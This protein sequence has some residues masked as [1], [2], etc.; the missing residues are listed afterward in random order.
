MPE[1][2]DTYTS[3]FTG[4]RL[5]CAG[6]VGESLLHL[7]MLNG[8]DIHIKVAKRL[9]KFY[10]CQINDI[11]MG[12]DY[13]GENALHMAIVAENPSLVKYLLMQGADY[14]Q[15]CT[16]KFFTAADQKQFRVDHLENEHPSLPV[17]SNYE[18]VSYFGEYPLS[19]AAIMNQEECIRLLMAKGADPN[20]QDS[21][22]NTVLHMLVINDMLD[23]FKIMLT[24]KAR[25]DIKNRQGL[26][27][28]TLAAKLARYNMF[29]FILIQQRKLLWKY[30][31]IT[32][33]A[34][35]IDTV[36]TINADGTTDT[37]SAL[38]II[39]NGDKVEHLE[40]LE[41]LIIDLLN[42]KWQTFVKRK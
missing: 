30:A 28:L 24:F 26:T 5:D 41:G 11:Y 4:L 22:G 18:G 16:G 40:L 38:Y 32:C 15:R 7:C 37:T 21:N 17:K 2:K 27:P 14:H 42:V 31:N 8:T 25:L 33:G 9:L 3:K 34:Y 6:A 10:P 20:K 19:F 13:Y 12:E 35:P 36:D 1:V 23:M 29:Q 39:C